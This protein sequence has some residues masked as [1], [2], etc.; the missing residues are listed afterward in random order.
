LH[1]AFNR[2]AGTPHDIIAK[3]NIAKINRA[4]VAALADSN[5]RKRFAYMGLEVPPAEQQT[6]EV[7]GMFQRAE[8]EKWWPII[9]AFGIKAE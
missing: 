5:V 6:P 3:I 2:A 1:R 4:V 8:I 7:L 9:K